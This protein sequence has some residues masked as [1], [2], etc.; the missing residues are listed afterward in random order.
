MHVPHLPFQHSYGLS[1]KTSGGGGGACGGTASSSSKNEEDRH[2]RTIIIEKKNQSYGFTLQSYGI[3]Y[4]REQELEML[5]YVDQVEYDGPAYKA[6]MR[7]GD[8]ILSI[9]GVDMEKADHSALVAFIKECDTRM[10]MVVLFEDCVRKVS[11]HMRYLHLQNLLQNKVTELE[12]LLQREREILEGKWKTHSLPAR[13]KASSQSVDT[14]L[15]C[16]DH[17]AA[18]ASDN[19]TDDI[20]PSAGAH[21]G[22]D[23]S[24]RVLAS[25][26]NTLP[27]T[28]TA[29]STE[30]IGKLGGTTMAGGG[31]MENFTP[32]AQVLLSYQYMD[33]TSR[34]NLKS[35]NSS[36]IDSMDCLHRDGAAGSNEGLNYYSLKSNAS[37]KSDPNLN[38]QPRSNCSTLS[39]RDAENPHQSR[40][41]QYYSNLQENQE[42]P[43]PP[44]S[45]KEHNKAGS[46]GRC[47]QSY[48]CNPCMGRANKKDQQN[49]GGDNVSLDAYDL[50]GSPSMCC[51]PHQ[52][53]P[54]RRRRSKHHH[55][56]HQQQ[57]ATPGDPRHN[58][59][60]KENI[61][62]QQETT[63]KCHHHHQQQKHQKHKHGTG[64]KCDEERPQRP[65]SQSNLPSNPAVALLQYQ[66]QTRY[67]E[68]T[69]ADRGA[70]RCSLHSCSHN[71]CCPSTTGSYCTSLS[72]DTLNEWQDQAQEMTATP[73][74]SGKNVRM[75]VH[76]QGA[77]NAQ[78]IAQP[79]QFQGPHSQLVTR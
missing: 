3:H 46:S 77:G 7:E 65:K 69:A 50:A 44:S 39:K 6:G 64:T 59:Y 5:T 20:Y 11:L 62:A 4:K 29:V 25:K 24:R 12:A 47:R 31:G 70:S 21:T 26:T 53:V 48:Y 9:N 19:Y 30:N 14:G 40:H 27:I 76:G 78:Y 71:D 23:H 41:A 2:R 38:L 67:C 73:N 75:I 57:Q 16:H 72:A 42:R 18:A 28:R 37:N 66:K 58:H 35:S 60:S 36:G 52:C 1:S 79:Q 68:L 45:A 13:K 54:I 34:S 17:S 63:H 10:R 74:H 33:P 22:S 43:P 8:V 61:N 32:N 15:G 55:H 56:H 51:D 49:G